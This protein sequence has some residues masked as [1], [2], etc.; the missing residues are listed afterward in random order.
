MAGKVWSLEFLNHNSQRAYPLSDD[1]T[2]TD[3][4]GVF[5]L[6]DDFLVGMT[7][8]VNAGVSVLPDRFY[9][10]TLGVFPTGYSITIG[11]YSA[12]NEAIDVATAMI[13]KRGHTPYKVYSLG[14]VGDFEDARGVLAI[15][16]LENIDNQPAGIFTFDVDSARLEMDVIRPMLR[17]VTGIV[18]VNG[19]RRSDVLTGLIEINA[20]LRMRL[21]P[22]QVLNSNP[23]VRIDAIDGEG[24]NDDC[25]CDGNELGDPIRML[26]RVTPA[27]DGN[28]DLL[29]NEC[30]EIELEDHGIRFKDI[31]SKPCCGC[32]ELERVTSDLQHIADQNNLAQLF[33]T[34]LE[35]SV[36]QMDQ[37]VL[38]SRLN[39][40]GCLECT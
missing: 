2:R 28:I 11:Y 8:S 34:R 29:G 21:T 9:L 37:V 24:L 14:G 16:R 6:P 38:G 12:T 39:D 35:A 17:G 22:S 15:G 27:A 36:T 40:E 18:V 31:C 32:P 3:S 19:T 10:K 23:A 33:L 13:P 5:T 26:S 1:S 4:S 20:G 25:S 7:L 30:L